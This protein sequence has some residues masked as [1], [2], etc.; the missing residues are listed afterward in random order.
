MNKIY[1][2]ED[3]DVMLANGCNAPGCKHEHE[4]MSELFLNQH[5]HAGAGVEALYNAEG[6]IVLTCRVCDAHIVTIK[7]GG[8][9]D[10]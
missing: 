1:T 4:K 5:C 7:V 8:N 9:N 6:I 2:R 10:D 3:L